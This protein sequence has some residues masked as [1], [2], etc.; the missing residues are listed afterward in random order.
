MPTTTPNAALSANIAQL[1]PEIAVVIPCHNDGA[2]ISAAVASATGPNVEVVVV[3]NGSD[4][5]TE[6]VL[7]GLTGERVRVI[8]QRRRGVAAARMAGVSAT[9]ARF[10]VPLDADDELLPGAVTRLIGVLADSDS[11]CVFAYGD[12]YVFGSYQ[13]VYRAPPAFEPWRL[14]YVNPYPV[15]CMLRRSAVL[16][17]GGWSLLRGYEDWDLWLKVAARGWYGVHVGR[18][19]YRRRI[20]GTR[21]LSNARPH[22][23]EHVRDLRLR[24][25]RFLASYHAS[26]PPSLSAIYGIAARVRKI[27][28]ERCEHAYKRAI[29]ACLGCRGGSTRRRSARSLER[30]LWDMAS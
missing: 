30:F 23:R 26:A 25:T 14:R 20:H 21:M 7:A 12:Y 4:T 10:V 28:P 22:D 9:K 1:A 3:D 27:V 2:T 18:A 8:R 15:T 6:S 29:G 24:H 13:S 16:D 19:V 17:L 11:G 5:R